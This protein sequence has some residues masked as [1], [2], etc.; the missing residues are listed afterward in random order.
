MSIKMEGAFFKKMS[1]R[2][3]VRLCRSVCVL[4]YRSGS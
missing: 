2:L 1:V 3:N 4:K